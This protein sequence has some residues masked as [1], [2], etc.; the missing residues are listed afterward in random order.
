MPR[1]VSLLPALAVAAMLAAVL[2]GAG[3]LA[4]PASAA[5]DESP[6]SVTIDRLTPAEIP[7]RGPVTVGGTITNHD[8][9]AWSAIKLYAF[10]SNAPMTS[11]TELA[12]AAA[13]DPEADV[14][15]RITSDGTFD[16]I[17]AL[18]PGESTR[19]F[20]RIPRSEFP[21]TAPGVYWFGVH[22]LGET[23]EGRLDGAD[24]RARTFLPLAE[25]TNRTVDT[26][27][28][29][30][31]RRDITYAP[32]GRLSDVLSWT[33]TLGRGGRLSSLV[34]LGAA[35]GLRP[36]SWLV[37]PAVVDAARQLAAGNPP[38]S[39]GPTVD[40]SDKGESESPE[41][42]AEPSSEDAAETDGAEPS[43]SAAAAA[44]WLDR[45]HTALPGG[46]I[47]TLP[48]GD[49]DVAGAAD[50]DP[51]AYRRA[52]RRSGTE[53]QPWGL[54]ATPAVSS[55][56]GFLDPA[57]IRLADPGTTLIVTDQMFDGD[58]P[59]VARTV[60]RKLVVASSGAA[61]GGPG[62]DDPF[63]TVEVRQRIV[64]EA[65]LRVQEPRPEPLVVVL[66][67]TWTPQGTSG[68]FDGLDLDWLNLTTVDRA[69]QRAATPVPVDSLTYPELQSSIE[70][71]AG[72]FTA[73]SDL[74]RA[75]DTLQNLLTRNEQ[76]GSDVR[77]E[78]F[79]V[80]SYY[81]RPEPVSAQ[82][83]ADESRSWIEARLQSVHIDAP[84]AVIL[85]SGSGRFAATVTNGL[86]QPVTVK[87]D[88]VPDP[89]LEISVPA[90]SVAIGPGSRTTVLLNASSSALGVRNVKLLLTDSEDV[91]LG[92]SDDLPIRSNRV[93]NVIWLILGTGVALL[94]GAIAVRLF[95]RIRAA[96]RS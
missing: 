58:A 69:A 73:A 80:V 1:P 5:E 30:P 49:V 33:R 9:E 53:L 65:A 71:D 87:V 23:S 74:A 41:P 27:L 57:G 72:N 12:D 29:V 78:A 64:S 4:A 94:F 45:L 19:Y 39:L 91:P 46:E 67:S 89:P 8:D 3:P 21:V 70:L 54:P 36:I 95:R 22:A 6:L 81:N 24:G 26:A 50:H 86:D 84:K 88:A 85:S 16:E 10:V 77:D 20:L 42:S 75:G 66:P 82:I 51:D 59:A 76:V 11:A 79:S 55:P 60:D 32:D 43:P 40:E 96:A 90:E 14:G 13:V 18:A 17:D 31:I 56:S 93:S 62:P 37:D 28:V 34:D 52:Q 7:R 38:R 92:S 68:F 83:A 15:G 48:Y 44:D 47:L 61:D 35:S 25:P 63:S 2:L